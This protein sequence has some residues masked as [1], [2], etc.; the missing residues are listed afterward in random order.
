MPGR[1]LTF[2]RAAATKL[3][4]RVALFGAGY[5]TEE[6][7]EGWRLLHKACG[8]VPG[9]ASPSDDAAARAAIAEIDAWDEPGFRRIGAALGRLH[10]EQQAFVFAGIEA[11]RGAGSLLAVATLLE[12]LDQLEKGR[13]GA[14]GGAG[15]RAAVAADRAAIATLTARGITPEVRGR[16]REL[17]KVAQTAQAPVFPTD[18]TAAEREAALLELRAWYADWSETARAVIQRR[19]YL[20]ML[21]LTQRKVSKDAGEGDADAD[22]SGE[23]DGAGDGDGDGDVDATLP[24]VGLPIATTVA[25]N[26]AQVV[27]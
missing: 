12:R 7:D 8:H 3:E 16:L 9:V 18:A 15:S 24:E 4:I 20:V 1:V 2:L 27:P 11:A 23:T 6:Q 19:D 10:P 13:Q 25:G 14:G 22:S 17:V 5:T 21:G 26:G